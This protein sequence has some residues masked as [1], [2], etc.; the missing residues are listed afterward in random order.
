[1]GYRIYVQERGAHRHTLLCYVES[2]PEAVADALRE[3]TLHV[4]DEGVISKGPHVYGGRLK[5]VSKYDRVWVV[6]EYAES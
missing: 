4:R 6:K 3:K 1:M 5:E 2:N